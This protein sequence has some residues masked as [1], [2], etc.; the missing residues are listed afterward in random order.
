MIPNP[1]RFYARQDPG[2]Q[3]SKWAVILSAC[4]LFPATGPQAQAQEN[5]LKNPGFEE[6]ASRENSVPNWT[7]MAEG[8]GRAQLSDT[9]PKSGRQCLAI[10]AHTAVE[11][12]VEKAEAG[13]YVARCWIN[14]QS[15]QSVT[16]ILEDAD[17]PWAATL[18]PRSGCRASDGCKSRSSA[19]WTEAG[20][21]PS[22]SARTSER[23]PLLP[24]HCEMEFAYSG[25]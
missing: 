15:E 7:S 22:I 9:Q 10:P 16:L 8:A 19:R 12:K 21:W 11:Q 20:R 18:A 3:A 17:R 1:Q 13:A 6:G 4:L 5:L 25:R 23:I 14:S 24:R 2:S